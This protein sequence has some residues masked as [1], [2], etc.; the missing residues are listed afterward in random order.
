MVMKFVASALCL[1]LIQG[2]AVHQAPYITY[3]D[4]D[5]SLANTAVLV[6]HVYNSPDGRTREGTFKVSGV[7]EVDGSSLSCL[8][9]CPVWVRVLPGRHTFKIR[10][11]DNFRLGVGVIDYKGADI[12]VT[13][14]DMKPGHTYKLSYSR[15]SDLVGIHVEDLGEKADFGMRICGMYGDCKTMYRATFD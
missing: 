4:R 13:I 2:C 9:A 10:Y 7:A 3:P 15:S 1:L 5:G 8:N 11:Q 14:D 6:A 12:P